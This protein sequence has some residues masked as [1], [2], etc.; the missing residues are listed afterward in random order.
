MNTLATAA[1]PATSSKQ[2]ATDSMPT[3]MPRMTLVPAPV[4]AASATRRTG[5]K[6]PV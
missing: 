1:T 3:A 4:M 5:L 6:L 2:V